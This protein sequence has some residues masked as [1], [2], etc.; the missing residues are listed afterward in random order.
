MASGPQ[1]TLNIIGQALKRGTAM[2]KT[3]SQILLQV[4]DEL[5]IPE[6]YIINSPRPATTPVPELS[7]PS[8]MPFYYPSQEVEPAEKEP[9]S[10]VIVIDL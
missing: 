10:V 7:L 4:T 3:K 9:Q 5:S 1:E 2:R 8:P 6:P